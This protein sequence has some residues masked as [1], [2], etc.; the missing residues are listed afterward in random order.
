M[1]KISK[2]FSGLSL[3]IG[4]SLGHGIKHFGQGAL[5]VIGPLLKASMGLSE[6]SYALIFS[7]MNVSSGLSNIPAGILSDMYRK[8]IAWFLAISMFTISI[9]YLL[10]GI[11]KIYIL[12]LLGV[13]LIGFGTSFW[14]A[15]AF[16]TLAARYP[17]RKGFALSMHL[18]GAQIGNTIGPPIIG[19]LISGVTL[20]SVI[21]FSGFGWE[22]VAIMIVIPM[23]ITGVLVLT[24]FKSA[25]SESTSNW[26]FEEYWDRTK[27]LLADKIILGLIVLG[28]MRASIHTSFQLW[29]AVYL[30][31]ELDYSAWVIGWHIAL[32]TA[33][34]IIST[35]IMGILS[36]R[37]G[38]KPV[39]QISM[40]LMAIYLFLFLIF[41][42]GLGLVILIGLLG[43]FFFSV[44]PIVTAAT[45]DR[46]PKGSEGSG[47]ALNFIGM[48]LIGFMAPVISGIIYKTYNF[49]G[50]AIFS[51]IIAISGILLCTFLPMKKIN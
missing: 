36:D 23:I 48:S 33:A 25:G 37:F 1:S 35:P 51:G 41:D 49:E 28:A 5:T 46:V 39:I 10:I 50:I 24:M 29:L 3:V 8:K 9:G 40:T 4:L 47:T 27:T 44:M 31:E 32:I 16:G 17:E 6:V 7:S 34:G 22:N 45:M 26:S 43:M 42:E 38:R 13:I 18:T 14:H 19:G 21:K 30:K 12:I 20:G 15:P 11:T 2:P